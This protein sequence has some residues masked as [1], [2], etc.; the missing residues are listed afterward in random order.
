[1]VSLE[2][3]KQAFEVLLEN[4]NEELMNQDDYLIFLLKHA[5]NHKVNRDDLVSALIAKILKSKSPT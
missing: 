3:P 1:M 2:E 4:V 5:I